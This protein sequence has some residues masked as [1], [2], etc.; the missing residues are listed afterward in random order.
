MKKYR[1][2]DGLQ[3]GE[4]RRGS[5]YSEACHNKPEG[6]ESHDAYA[7]HAEIYKQS[8]NTQKCTQKPGNKFRSSKFHE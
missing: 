4:E 2:E 3:S 5:E 6:A 8:Q 1:I 7:H